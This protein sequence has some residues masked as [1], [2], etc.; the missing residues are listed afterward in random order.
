M[1][2]T[3]RKTNAL[4]RIE[5]RKIK[6]YYLYEVRRLKE[7]ITALTLDIQ[8]EREKQSVKVSV[9]YEIKVNT[10]NNNNR[11]PLDLIERLEYKKGLLI[12][13]YHTKQKELSEK[14]THRKQGTIT[15]LMLDYY[16]NC[17]D[18]KDMEGIYNINSNTITNILNKYATRIELHHIGLTT[19]DRNLICYN[20]CDNATTVQ[21][22]LSKEQYSLKEY[23][24]LYG[25]LD[26][27]ELIYYDI[28]LNYL[29]RYEF[30]VYTLCKIYS[31]SMKDIVINI[32]NVVNELDKYLKD[33][34]YLK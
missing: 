7:E 22:F 1:T 11:T 29:I 34:N 30:D 10:S 33:N 18:I 17:R 14:I 23:G 21:E 20:Y 3:K 26:H 19:Y 9:L 8:A 12:K 25:F 16:I 15:N 13:K 32:S 24:L 28:L 5:V 27:K 2:I 31:I 4:N 6:E